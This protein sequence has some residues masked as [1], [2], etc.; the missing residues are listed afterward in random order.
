MTKP[1]QIPFDLGHRQAYARE[2]IWVSSANA[3][4]VAWIDKW[5]AWQQGSG[6]VLHGPSASG[7][8]H[9]LRI[10]QKMSGAPDLTP[11]N[12]PRLA[13]MPSAVAV[14]DAD[15]LIGHAVSEE[16]LFHL[17]NAA[18]EAGGHVLLTSARPP[19]ELS[20]LLPDL[21]SR[22]LALP[23][24]AV[25]VPDEALLAIVLAKMFSDRQ[26]FVTQ[27]V[28]DFIMPRIRRSFEAVRAVANEI[29][30]QAMAQKRP[31]TVPLVRD[32]LNRQEKI[33]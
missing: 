12:W 30:R 1:E 33:F 24:V 16:W 2:D 10:W 14:D 19:Q 20:L 25:G 9:L 8:T 15:R 23:A 7:K 6:L 17:L 28:I 3:A 4:A 5:P 18:K 32:I 26:I 13:D 27:D 11:E 21:R 29:D 22:L 31:V